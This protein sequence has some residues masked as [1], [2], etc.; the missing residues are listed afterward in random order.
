MNVRTA[1]ITVVQPRFEDLCERERHEHPPAALAAEFRLHPDTELHVTGAVH[2]MKKAE[3]FSCIPH[4]EIRI[5][6]LYRVGDRPAARG[7]FVPGGKVV[8]GILSVITPRH[9]LARF[10]IRERSD[11]IKRKIRFGQKNSSSQTRRRSS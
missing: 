3:K 4:G 6:A 8:D 7:A 10:L 5:F 2:D 9:G 1:S 11:G